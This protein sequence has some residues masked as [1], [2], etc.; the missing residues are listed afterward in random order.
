MAF[1]L[2]Q[3]NVKSLFNMLS[4]LC[5]MLAIVLIWNVNYQM[6]SFLSN[7]CTWIMDIH[8]VICL[9]YWQKQC[10]TYSQC[11]IVCRT[12]TLA[13]FKTVHAN[14]SRHY[15]TYETSIMHQT[16]I[17]NMH[18]LEALNKISTRCFVKHTGFWKKRVY[19]VL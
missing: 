11:G 10:F 18:F 12:E 13:S 7:Y 15:F 5:G 1:Y 6:H 3:Y 14:F 16:H 17:F 4:E 8:N 9:V 2:F 19:C